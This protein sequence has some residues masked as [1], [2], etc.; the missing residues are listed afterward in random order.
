MPAIPGLGSPLASTISSKAER[1]S[2]GVVALGMGEV[3]PLGVTACVLIGVTGVSEPFA[4]PAPLRGPDR[5]AA[6][7]RR[8]ATR[9]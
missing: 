4:A 8:W 3:C 2:D 1:L 9:L 6:W 5:P 7:S